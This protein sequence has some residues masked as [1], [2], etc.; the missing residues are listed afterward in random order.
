MYKTL[1][2]FAKSKFS[3]TQDDVKEIH[4]FTSKTYQKPPYIE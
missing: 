2:Y 4:A 3:K 1:N